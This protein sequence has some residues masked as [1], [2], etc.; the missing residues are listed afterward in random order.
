MVKHRLEDFFVQS[1]KCLYLFVSV[2]MYHYEKKITLLFRDTFL[3][4][5]YH[6][7]QN[8]KTNRRIFNKKFCLL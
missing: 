8:D 6:Y 1:D 2:E 5:I 4:N 3:G 7:T